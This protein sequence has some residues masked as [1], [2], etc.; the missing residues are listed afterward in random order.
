MV[1]QG[2]K[3]IRPRSQGFQADMMMRREFGFVLIV[4]MTSASWSWPWP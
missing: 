3:A 4:L 2:G 1:W